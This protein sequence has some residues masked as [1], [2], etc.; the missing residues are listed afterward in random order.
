MKKHLIA[1][2]FLAAVVAV[3]AGSWY[4]NL[5]TAVSSATLEPLT[6]GLPMQ[7]GSGLVMVALK[8]RFFEEEGLSVEVKSYP[9]GKRAL[10]EGLF[11][12]KLDM[13]TVT[14]T[15]VVF[16]AFERSDFKVIAALSEADNS[17][18]IIANKKKGIFTPS[19][20]RGKHIATQQ[21]SAVHFFLSLFLLEH[22]MKASDVN[23]TF[24]KCE[25]Q[26]KAL[27][28]ERV[29]AVSIREP[30]FSQAQKMLGKDAVVFSSPGLYTQIEMA[31]ASDTLLREHPE[32]VEKFL[33]G[34]L[35]AETYMKEH[36][37]ESIKLIS[38][39]LNTPYKGFLS[40]AQNQ[41]QVGL[42]QS[43]VESFDDQG[44]WAIS[45]KLV[46]AD[47][48]PDYTKIIDDRWLKKLKP[49]S[50]TIIR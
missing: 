17:N 16:A 48:I 21:A 14:D 15:P 7:P 3:I 44:R 29:D 46:K 33:R 28:N 41:Y 49:Q 11:G 36:Q 1:M 12:S 34:V 35:R 4:A 23:L 25:T 38:E 10:E 2:V 32:R 13:A 39:Y 45:D 27:A 9:S 43:L 30:F 50:V 19:D 47:K 42:G 5:K 40:A 22:G 8:K 31:V 18:R 37:Q 24:S 6:I 26:P 20:L